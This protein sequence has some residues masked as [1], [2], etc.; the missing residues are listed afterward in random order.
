M[1]PW[2]YHGLSMTTKFGIGIVSRKEKVSAKYNWPNSTVTLFSEYR[3][4]RIHP[5]KS[6]KAK[7]SQ[8][9][10]VEL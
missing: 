9:T 5:S 3:R 10:L 1:T 6:H 7:R 4:T 8:L 2:L